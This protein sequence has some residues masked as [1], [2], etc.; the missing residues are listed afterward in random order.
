MWEKKVLHNSRPKNLDTGEN[1]RDNKCST[2]RAIKKSMRRRSVKS[3]FLKLILKIR[4]YGLKQKMANCQQNCFRKTLTNVHNQDNVECLIFIK[5]K[6][7]LKHYSP[8]SL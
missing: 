7:K 4:K 1:C 2:K 6:K 3:I 8:T 5:L